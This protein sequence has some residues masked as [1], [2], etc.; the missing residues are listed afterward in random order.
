ML[1]VFHM[2]MILYPMFQGP[3]GLQG[4]PGVK[5]CK[6]IIIPNSSSKLYFYQS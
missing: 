5:V 4:P 3:M 2:I 1:L 6:L